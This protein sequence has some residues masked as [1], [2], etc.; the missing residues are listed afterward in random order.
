M[1]HVSVPIRI[2]GLTVMFRLGVPEVGY[3]IC[4]KVTEGNETISNL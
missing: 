2:T 1:I 3:K 4:L